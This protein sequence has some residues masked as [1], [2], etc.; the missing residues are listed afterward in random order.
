MRATLDF[1][2][3]VDHRATQSRQGGKQNDKALF[4]QVE[5]SVLKYLSNRR[6]G[7]V[8][9][10]IEIGEISSTTGIRD[11]EEVLRALYTLEGK[12][13]VEPEPR[14]DF[15]S[16]IWQITDIGVRALGL[17]DTGN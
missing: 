5:Y 17:V 12:S 3:S 15:T 16:N 14:G 13:L 9:G 6:H 7:N 8:E 11:S 4:S 2:S 1:K 10:P